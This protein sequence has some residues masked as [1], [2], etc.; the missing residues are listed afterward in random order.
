MM[1]LSRQQSAET[2]PEGS[3][4]L[5]FALKQLLKGAGARA[6]PV[7]DVEGVNAD[8]RAIATGEVFFALP[9]RGCMGTAS[10]RR[11]SAAALRQW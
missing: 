4:D 5:P 1:N 9:G 7:L 10:L 2:T 8:S 3:E 11:P 6:V